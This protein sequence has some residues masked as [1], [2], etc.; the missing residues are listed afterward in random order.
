MTA[1]APGFRLSKL[2]IAVLIGGFAAAVIVGLLIVWLGFAIAFVLAHFFLFCNVFR[3]ARPL[4]LT[5]AAAF[6]AL[7]SGT[8][9]FEFPGWPATAVVSL[10]VTVVVVLLEMRKPSYH[11]VGWAWINP[12]LRGWWEKRAAERP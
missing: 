2:D 1:F 8:L 11:G 6:V 9:T 4:E 3:L 12:G 10:V 5:W 7:A